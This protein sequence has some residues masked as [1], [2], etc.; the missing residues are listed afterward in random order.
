MVEHP[1]KQD[2]NSDYD[3]AMTWATEARKKEE[4]DQRPPRGARLKTEE[5]MQDD[6]LG[7]KQLTE[8][9][10]KSLWTAYVPRGMKRISEG[11]IQPIFDGIHFTSAFV[12]FVNNR[13]SVIEEDT[14]GIE[15]HLN[16]GNLPS[17][18]PHLWE[19]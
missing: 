9:T 4:K 19:K 7:T 17:L 2:Q 15:K 11:H 8:E 5:R 13:E 16:Q 1:R 3:I 6:N 10:G 14:G 18:I 12:V